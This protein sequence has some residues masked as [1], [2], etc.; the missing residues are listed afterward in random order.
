MSE[1]YRF[2][3]KLVPQMTVN[4][5]TPMPTPYLHSL[6]QTHKCHW[7]ICHV[8]E[9]NAKHVKLG[10]QIWCE[11]V[12]AG[13][14]HVFTIVQTTTE[15]PPLKACSFRIKFQPVSLHVYVCIFVCLYECVCVHMCPCLS[16]YVKVNSLEFLSDVQFWCVVCY[17]SCDFDVFNRMPLTS[18]MVQSW[19]ALSTTRAWGIIA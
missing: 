4:I 15:I 3:D 17:K 9:H 7:Y 19:S 2:E 8:R 5:N 13:P 12:V 16:V 1:N 18:C 6:T 11:G 14:D 10:I